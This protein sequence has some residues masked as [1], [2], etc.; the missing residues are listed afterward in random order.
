MC[1][2]TVNDVPKTSVFQKIKTKKVLFVEEINIQKIKITNVT[3]M[4]ISTFC[5]MHI[6]SK[7]SIIYSIS[8]HLSDLGLE[9][10]RR[11]AFIHRG[12][13]RNM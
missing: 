12:K 9:I 3:A 6:I 7:P 11:G 13:W 1:F 4:K 10:I 5:F 8:V 2:T